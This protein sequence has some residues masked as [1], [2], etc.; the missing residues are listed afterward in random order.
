LGPNLP[1]FLICWRFLPELRLCISSRGQSAGGGC[2][3]SYRGACFFLKLVMVLLPWVS[4]IPIAV[5]VFF[6]S[7]R[8]RFGVPGCLFPLEASPVLIVLNVHEKT[9]ESLKAFRGSWC[10]SFLGA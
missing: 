1:G 5:V 3:N 8:F 4:A 2:C 6:S 7:A 10:L 9:P